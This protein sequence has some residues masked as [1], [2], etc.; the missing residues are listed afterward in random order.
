MADDKEQSQ[1]TE[2]PTPRRLEEARKKG[3]ISFSR[4]VN[5]FLL[6]ML[7][8]LFV[9]WISPFLLKRA[10]FELMPYIT[11]LDQFPADFDADDIMR[12]SL[13]IIYEILMLLAIPLAISM[14]GAVLGNF[15]QGAIAYSMESI[16]PSLSKISPLKGLKRIF[17]LKSLV[18]FIKGLFK[19]ALVGIAIY[20]AIRPEIDNL[21]LLH[22]LSFAGT[23]DIFAAAIRKMLLTV[24]VIMG[25]IAAI[26]FFYQRYE[27]IKSLM[28]TREE[29]K[30]EYKQTEGSPE[31][32]AKIRQI[33]RERA[34]KQTMSQV[35]K[36]TALITNPTHYSIAI[37]YT[38]EMHAPKIIAKGL[39]NIALKMREVAKEHKVPIFENPPLARAL[40]ASTEVDEFIP[41]EHYK[42]VAEIVSKIMS[43]D[44][45]LKRK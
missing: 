29:V 16:T 15:M 31:V 28:M 27:Y 44:Q 10:N 33:R 18:E 41:F 14:I 22:T 9:V 11:N 4:E 23:M 6:L 24:C 38:D 21:V 20:M 34:M 37:L 25:V 43:I 26:D 3:N 32:K 13:Q 5:S 39:D 40:Y 35:P 7:V 12:L 42:A 36:A 1:K 45:G 8:T 19:I 2:Q 17:S 30:E